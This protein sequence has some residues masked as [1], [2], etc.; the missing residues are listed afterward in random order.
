MTEGNGSSEP[1]PDR[2][3]RHG[4]GSPQT[5]PS[6]DRQAQSPPSKLRLLERFAREAVELLRAS[7]QCRMSL[8]RFS[9]AWC[10]YFNRPLR[11]SEFGCG[12]LTDLL[13]EVSDR[14]QVWTFFFL[15]EGGLQGVCRFQ[16]VDTKE[17]WVTLTPALLKSALQ[18]QIVS[19]LRQQPFHRAPM[20]RLVEFYHLALGY[21]LNL[22]WFGFDKIEDVLANMRGVVEVSRRSYSSR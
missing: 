3:H 12:K 13:A 22:R 15:A 8:S 7:P 17:K 1:A 21:A 11:L 4:S 5:G 19:I 2:R 9:S 16:I 14:L 20:D 6:S 18:D 10:S